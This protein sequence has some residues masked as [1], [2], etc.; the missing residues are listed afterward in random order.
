MLSAVGNDTE[1]ATEE[2]D[3]DYPYPTPI[4]ICFNVKYL[5]DVAQQIQNAEME[6]MLADSDSSVL[7][8]PNG[9]PHETYILM[10]M[11]V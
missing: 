9:N 8:R 5:T 11:R 7:V 3:V 2:L 1:S 4:E 10:P 6:F